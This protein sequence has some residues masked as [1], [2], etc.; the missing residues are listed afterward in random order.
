M[1]YLYLL[2]NI[3]T[4]SVPLV[5]SF[6]PKI[7]FDKNW[8]KFFPAAL[9]TGI[10]FIIWDSLFT[11]MGVWGFNPDYLTG[12]Y[13]LNLPLEEVLFFICIPFACVF[14]YH[15][16]SKFRLAT[17]DSGTVRIIILVFAVLL[18]FAGIMFRNKLYTS[19]TALSSGIVLLWLLYISRVNWLGQALAVY[20]LLLIPFLIVN[21]VLTGTGIDAPVVWYDESEIVGIRIL[22]IPVEDVFYGM[23][24]ILLNIYLYKSFFRK[25]ESEGP[26]DVY[27]A[28]DKLP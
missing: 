26:A 13:I 19:L 21:G 16:I 1:K 23:E 3:L 24:L 8:N 11:G 2:V 22:T 10:I 6:H 25:S 7:R 12:L 20:A 5:F 14:T 18:L 27:A 28:A 17:K 15:C 4:I 9:L